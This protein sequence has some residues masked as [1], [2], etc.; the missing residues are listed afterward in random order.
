[1]NVSATSKATYLHFDDT[2]VQNKRNLASDNWRDLSARSASYPS[3]AVERDVNACTWGVHV[4]MIRNHYPM[5]ATYGHDVTVGTSGFSWC[6]LNKGILRS[7]RSYSWENN[8]HIK[9]FN[10]LMRLLLKS[11]FFTKKCCMYFV[12]GLA[13]LNYKICDVLISVIN[14][15]NCSKDANSVSQP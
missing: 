12:L 7:D 9:C 1:M 10:Y 3:K 8:T 4:K 14:V 6:Q 5:T 13:P 11:R 2:S 15:C